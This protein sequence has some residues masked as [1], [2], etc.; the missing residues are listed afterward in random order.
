M[1]KPEFWEDEKLS[2]VSYQAR[3]TYIAVW[4]FSDDY[5]VVKGNPVWLKNRIF[6]YDDKL[7]ITGFQNCLQE[8]CDLKRLLP[9]CHNGESFF[10]IPKFT[11]HQKINRPSGR[12]NPAPPDGI[13]NDC[14]VSLN[15]DS[16]SLNDD[17]CPKEKEKEKEK[18]KY[19]VEQKIPY[20]SIIQFLNEKSG[21]NFKHNSKNTR[22]LIRARWNEGFNE[23]QFKTV[24]LNMC[25]KWLTDEKMVDYLRPQTL[26][27]TKFEAYL[28][29][30][31]K[32]SRWN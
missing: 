31:E 2:Q 3:L 6:P 29:T 21:K 22:S 13:N 10:Y 12:K 26:F 24:I 7:S 23:D 19:N 4:N 27:G 30:K 5:G 28:N 20:E 25:R 8:L 11:E 15:D 9:F 16:V 17:S 32:G 18:E 1:I 14:S